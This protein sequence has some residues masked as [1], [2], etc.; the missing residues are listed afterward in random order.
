MI[1]Q[2]CVI[3]HRRRLDGSAREETPL[4]KKYKSFQKKIKRLGCW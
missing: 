4:E 1:L 3:Y 2:C